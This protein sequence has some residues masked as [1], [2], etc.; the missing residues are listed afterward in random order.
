[1]S[2]NTKNIGQVVGLFIS[3]V[4]PSNTT[5]IWYDETPNQRCH[6]V[7]N[8]TTKLWQALNPD[9]ISI[10]T[11][12]ELVNN[13]K[14]NGLSVGKKYQIRDK[15]GVLATVIT[16]TKI[17]Y[18]DTLGNILID[19]LGTN[20][21]YHVSSSN[22][23]IDDVN[24]VLNSSNQL[25]FSFADSTPNFETDY[26]FGK[27]R[28]GAKWVLSKFRLNKF[29]SKTTGNSISWKN[30]FFFNFSDAIK[31]IL[32]KTGGVVSK[33]SYDK[34]M[35]ELETSINNV[36]KENQSIISDASK[37]VADATTDSVIYNKKLPINIDTTVAAGD[38]QRLDS[39]ATIVS[40][41]QRWILKFKYATGIRLSRNF[42]DAK[43]AEFVNSN[44]TVESAFGKVQ[45]YLKHPAEIGML[46]GVEELAIE[47]DQNI[48]QSNNQEDFLPQ[49]NDTF[50]SAFAKIR[51]F[52]SGIMYH[53]HLPNNFKPKDYGTNV[54]LPKSG[55]SLNE[56]FAKA[57]AKFNQIGLIYNG[58]IE[59]RQRNTAD[60]S[61]V[62]GTPKM[63]LDLNQGIVTLRGN[64]STPATITN[65]KDFVQI[66]P[67]QIRMGNDDD[68][69]GNSL[70]IQ[71]G[72]FEYRGNGTRYYNAGTFLIKG[73]NGWM[74]PVTA[75]FLSNAA[76]ALSAKNSRGYEYGYYD[77]FFGN[78]KVGGLVLDA[79]YA[80]SDVNIAA[81]TSMVLCNSDKGETI[82]VYLPEDPES[83]RVIFVLRGG[84]GGVNIQARGNNGI[85]K[86]GSS[87]STIGIGARGQVYM[88]VFNRGITYSSE[89][90]QKF[91]LWSYS[92]LPH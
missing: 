82:T 81:N 69:L 6:K 77:A 64:G 10:T 57:V 32:D 51:L 22:I 53:I 43:K 91:G 13:A 23:F 11:Y 19:D 48:D 78:M 27:M 75:A 37:A 83:G 72:T 92:I 20:V 15:N 45:Y 87:I 28:V 4:P 62:E 47:I 74:V 55:D 9:I 56:A 60:A 61:T 38:I 63:R 40:K 25:I 65:K 89:N 79:I 59:S 24:G 30:G 34:K 5:L 1:M 39:L 44:D 52:F 18:V 35:R 84:N 88:F 76:T 14:K 54:E 8:P 3:T 66:T 16:P 50:L 29:L 67:S 12:S 33:S 85:D 86:I 2:S 58:V 73:A 36:S 7:Y 68:T 17:Q 70:N 90:P 46:D 80:E 42:A 26:F 41:V 31:G 71:R 49:N 21:Q